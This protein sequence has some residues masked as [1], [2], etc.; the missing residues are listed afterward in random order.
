MVAPYTNGVPAERGT[1][2]VK[3]RWPLLM[4][5]YPC[6]PL[7]SNMSV[8]E[9]PGLLK[10]ASWVKSCSSTNNNNDWI[11][12]YVWCISTCTV[13]T[14]TTRMIT[15]YFSNTHK[16]KTFAISTVDKLQYTSVL[17]FSCHT[18][19]ATAITLSNHNN[20]IIHFGLVI[21]QIPCDHVARAVGG[22]VS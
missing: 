17:A 6:R 14:N 18:P 16:K 7:K 15:T 13:E 9:Q 8:S 19:Q 4:I 11:S 2:R 10:L 5:P 20:N 1:S 3:H 22:K 21:R 12:S